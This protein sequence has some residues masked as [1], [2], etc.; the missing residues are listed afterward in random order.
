MAAVETLGYVPNK[1]ARSLV[2]RRNDSVTL[3]ISESEERFF[4]EPFFA[5]AVRGITG[6][7]AAD[8][9]DAAADHG[10]GGG[11]A[12]GPGELPDEPHVDG[13]MMMSLHG[14]DPFPNGWRARPAVVLGGR[15]PDGR[16]QVSYVDVDNVAGA[17]EAVRHLLRARSPSDRG[18]RGTRSTWR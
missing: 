5:A 11:A 6:A 8:V 16:G 3:V 1:A 15:P 14:Q 4:T 10:A 13:V 17:R 12:P 18:D 7:L 2:T 9:A